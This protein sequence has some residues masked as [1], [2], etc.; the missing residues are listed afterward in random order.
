MDQEGR[1]GADVVSDAIGRLT[2]IVALVRG[3]I[4]WTED[5][6]A[7]IAG[8]GHPIAVE[9]GRELFLPLYF[10]WTFCRSLRRS[11]RPPFLPRDGIAGHGASQFF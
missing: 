3:G 9:D 2:M 11:R 4:H 8:Q 7:A 10:R 5:Q 6:M 1:N